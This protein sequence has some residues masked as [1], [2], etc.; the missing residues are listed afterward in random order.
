MKIL[1]LIRHAKSSWKHN[2]PDIQRPL[3]ARGRRDAAFISK[4]MLKENVVPD[5]IFSS[6]ATRALSTCAIFME[7]LD[8]P[9]HLLTLNDGLYD[10]GG[11]KV[12]NFIRNLDD[13]HGSVFI[14][15]HNHAFT[16]IANA[17]GSIYFDNVPTC[18]VVKIQFDVDSWKHV[19]KGTTLNY[20]F[21]KKLRS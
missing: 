18:G 8:C 19:E 5:A 7:V 10:F 13:V 4:I 6:P 21:P 9:A 11:D 2:L 17:M 20:L 16:E 1:T 12:S 3:S 15:G 14:F